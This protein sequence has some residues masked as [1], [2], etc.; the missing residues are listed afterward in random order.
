[1][2]KFL[3]AILAGVMVCT[4]ALGTTN[5]AKANDEPIIVDGSELTNDESS[6]VTVEALTRGIY[7]KSGSSSL[8][9]KGNGK[10]AAGGDTIGQTKVDSISVYVRVQQ[11]LDGKW[12]AYTYWS[13]SDTDAYYVSTSKVLTVEKG[14]YYR[15]YCTHRADS[16][17]S[18]SYTSGIYID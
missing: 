14:Y 12:V 1:M 10:I 4:L 3:S 18:G 7:L 11:L 17:V 5:V 16:D 9:D 2:N 8:V 6:V 15:T 13:A